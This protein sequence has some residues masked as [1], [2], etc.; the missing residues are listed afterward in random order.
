[1]K[2]EDGH[3]QF[4]VKTHDGR[5]IV[6]AETTADNQGHPRLTLDIFSN[7]N[8]RQATVKLNFLQ[9]SNLKSALEALHNAMLDGMCDY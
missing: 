5:T 3:V 8:Q 1:M 4:L 7:D 2:K 9:I 6:L